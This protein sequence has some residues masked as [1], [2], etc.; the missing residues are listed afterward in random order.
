[1]FGS[2]FVS[3]SVEK[4]FEIY[5]IHASIAGHVYVTSK[6]SSQAKQQLFGKKKMFGIDINGWTS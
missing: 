4:S 6:T 1:M 5:A 3:Y 2:V